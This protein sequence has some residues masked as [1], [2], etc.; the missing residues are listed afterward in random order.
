MPSEGGVLEEEGEDGE[1]EEGAEFEEEEEE[2]W[3]AMALE[4]LGFS[5]SGL[6][7]VVSCLGRGGEGRTCSEGG[8]ESEEAEAKVEP[9]EEEEEEA[10]PKE[11]EEEEGSALAKSARASGWS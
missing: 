4:F 10:E 7:S 9:E 3:A 5:T 2:V 11:E 8:E 1:E 6:W